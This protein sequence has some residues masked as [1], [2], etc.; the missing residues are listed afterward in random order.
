MDSVYGARVGI[1]KRRRR[2][3]QTSS[4]GG[5]EFKT[6]VFSDRSRGSVSIISLNIF[7]IIKFLPFARLFTNIIFV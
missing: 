1:G 7:F 6:A 3:Q 4:P 5:N 2:H